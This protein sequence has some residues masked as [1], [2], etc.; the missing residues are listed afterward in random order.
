MTFLKIRVIFF[1]KSTAEL[2]ATA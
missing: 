1:I 2:T